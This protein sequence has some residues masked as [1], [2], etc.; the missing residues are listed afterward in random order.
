MTEF[1]ENN[2]HLEEIKRLKELEKL[3]RLRIRYD[4]DRLSEIDDDVEGEKVRALMFALKESG[5][6][7]CSNSGRFICGRDSKARE[8]G[9][10]PLEDIKYLYR[11]EHNRYLKRDLVY[12]EP[13]CLPHFP[14]NPTRVAEGEVIS[15]VVE[16]SGG[17]VRL[18][19][20]EDV[21]DV[22]IL[23]RFYR[24]VFNHFGLPLP[25]M[26]QLDQRRNIIEVYTYVR[27]PGR[28][29]FKV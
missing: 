29:E 27:S 1:E 26:M 24:S 2:L 20:G 14:V 28:L 7:A 22:P 16:R 10:V 3:L 25:K 18:L 23:N 6:G 12:L 19:D 11:E 15:E 5:M 13:Y 4:Q 8:I 9:I 21:V 17:L